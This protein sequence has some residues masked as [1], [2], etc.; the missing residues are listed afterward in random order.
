[1]LPMNTYSNQIDAS[2]API[3]CN[4]AQGNFLDSQI[5]DNPNEEVYS[6]LAC[7]IFNLV[8]CFVWLGVP[9][10]IF[11]CSARKKFLRGRL[12]Q[13]QYDAKLTKI[14]NIIGIS[15]GS[16]AIVIVLI[17]FVY[18]FII[19]KCPYIREQQ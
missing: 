4:L 11:S 15:F 9:A 18:Y 5:V 12:A 3:T 7:S 1:M 17:F 13:S 16:L 10:I 6:T 8:F 19:N 2:N 14:F